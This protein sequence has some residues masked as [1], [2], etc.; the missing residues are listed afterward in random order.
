VSLRSRILLGLAAIVLLYGSAVVAVEQLILRPG[1]ED[2][3]RTTTS[4]N[5][6]RAAHALDKDVE[7]LERFCHDWAAWDDTWQFLQDGNAEFVHENLVL[8]T[9]SNGNFDLV[10]IV[11]TDGRVAFGEARDPANDYEP[12]DVAEFPSDRVP[13][14]DPLFA[15]RALDQAVSGLLRTSRGIMLVSSW[16]VTDSLQQVESNGWIVMGRFLGATHVAELVDQ[17]RVPFVLSD[18]GAPR[19]PADRTALRRLV[20]GATEVQVPR[21]EQVRQAWTLL[22]DLR[23]QPAALLRTESQRE[24][25]RRGSGVL[26]FAVLSLL[27]VAT[28]LLFGVAFMMQRSVVRPLTE[29][30][31][32]A[33]SAGH[34]D[35]VLARVDSGRRDELGTLAREFDSMLA[36][37]EA[38]RSEAREAERVARDA[39]RAKSEFLA[40][41]SHEIRTPL[42]A[43]LGNADLL[44]DAGL[45][46]AAQAEHVQTI[47]RN[48]AHLMAVLNDILDLSRLEAGRMTM[49]SIACS[50]HALL[51][52]VADMVRAR[53]DEK[54]LRFE[55]GPAGPLPASIRTDPTRMRQILLNL[56]G[57]AVKFTQAGGVKLTACLATR[58]D[59]PEPA[60]D[61]LVQ[62]TGIG[63]TAEQVERLFRPFEQADSSTTRRFGGTGLGLVIS[64]RLARMLG[65]ELSLASQPGQGS[66]FTV[67]IPTG[68]L[69]GVP[70]VEQ[71]APAPV[72]AAAAP[73][74]NQRLSGRILLAEDT[75]DSALV[76]ATM[77][78]RAGAEVTIVGTGLAAIEALQSA[79]A[80]GQ[81]FDLALIDQHMPELDGMQATRRLRAEGYTRPIAALTANSL[82]GDRAE[83]IAAGCDEY[84]SKPVRR[85]ELVALCA[86]LMGQAA[87]PV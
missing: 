38:S 59:D 15:P 10:W 37:V 24:I 72:A 75:R 14:D 18:V 65:G 34:G 52:E 63:L 6:A 25:T 7:T 78:R 35:A 22:R 28:L 86:K 64:R 42:T 11:A 70:L 82:P 9:F 44:M 23:G 46:A 69:A 79:E 31:A 32:W 84:A 49:E 71:G 54:G 66:T 4:H 8:E 62:D 3:E 80:S 1:F 50:P 53:A 56:C 45:P 29:L 48:G 13:L 57:N 74:I 60:V 41:M 43:M 61:F 87:A 68:P 12:V 27:A 83:C 17:T 39:A 58:P 73:A 47:R 81:P 20:S 30:T 51:H 36:R 85:A 67:R 76:I 40:N 33:V 21:N 16:P 19:E 55:V 26:E 2:L 5:L 77:L